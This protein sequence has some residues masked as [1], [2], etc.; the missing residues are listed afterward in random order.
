MRA[1]SQHDQIRTILWV[2][3]V[4]AVIR[5]WVMPLWNSFW[6]DETVTVWAIRDGFWK[7]LQS[8]PS[9]PQS[10]SFCVLEWLTSRLG[11][12]HEATLRLPSLAAAIGTTFIYYR[13]GV[14]FLDRS[15]GL[16]LV[17]LYVTL[18][19]V[20]IEVPNARPYSI[21]L[22]FESAALLCLL[23]WLREG[24]ARDGI[25]WMTCAVLAGHFHQFFFMVLPLEGGFVL[26]RLYRRSFAKAS[27]LAV[28]VLI[29][30]A[31]LAPGVPQFLLL[32]RQAGNLSWA[33]QPSFLDLFIAVTPIYILAA[34]ALF[35]LLESA[36]GRHPR[37]AAPRPI[38]APALG[39]LVL[40]VPT[41]LAF[42]LS[43]L[44]QVHV[45]HARYLLPTVPGVVLLWG[46][47]LHGISSP[48]IR[49]M[50]LAGGLVAS[51]VVTGGLSAVP[52]YHEEDWRSAVA[53]LP[54]SGGML[55]YSGLVEAR[56]LDWLQLPERWSYL[57]AP[58]LAYR[59][60]LQPADAFVVPFDFNPAG[61]RYMEQMI[62]TQVRQRESV[63]VLTR[64]SFAGPEWDHWIAEQ[65]E[66][67]GFRRIRNS[68]YGRVEVDVF[69]RPRS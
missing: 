55:V 34:L 24:R 49:Q 9:T 63:T 18:Y 32:S 22:L 27:Q 35:A 13:I 50:S 69:Q 1:S 11:G 56:R 36:D 26:W 12:I 41:T 51:V 25:L 48:F 43:R 20:T 40:L 53:S 6:L 42:V 30:A 38:E 65:L 23:R 64:R 8:V 62:N 33:P 2:I 17:A 61:Q 31:V 54:D 21:A 7:I 28:C 46:W 16:S 4:I 68:A 52:D 14:E 60:N 3:V 10:I 57:M 19:Q 39:A 15:A 45:F 44:T 66:R 58:V 5:L 47:L 59:S 67:A 37:W 29:G